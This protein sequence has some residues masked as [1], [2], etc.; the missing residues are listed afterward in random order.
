MVSVFLLILVVVGAYLVVTA[1]STAYELT[2]LDRETARFQALSAFTGTGFTTRVSQLVVAHPMR[3]RITETL[4]LLGYASTATVVASLVASVGQETYLETLIN[5]G[6][7]A[8]LLA[9]GWSAL[10]KYRSQVVE[11]FFRRFLAPRITGDRVPHEEL[12]LYQKGFGLSRIEVPTD[13]RVIGRSLRQLR[14]R[15]SH[16]VQVLAVEEGE[17]VHPIPDPD[18][19]FEPGQHLIVYGDMRSLQDAFGP[20]DGS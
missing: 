2:G 20:E 7:M 16:R 14:L 4:I 6:I 18:W 12:L 13:S 9:V 3:R 1:G 11:D 8:A 19:L 5:L 10:R 15:T 17:D